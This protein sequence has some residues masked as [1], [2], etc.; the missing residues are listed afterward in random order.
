MVEGVLKDGV[1]RNGSS[2]IS[3]D[4][5]MLYDGDAISTGMGEVSVRSINHPGQ[6]NMSVALV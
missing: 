2:L 4:V 3:I 6:L 5:Y 1:R